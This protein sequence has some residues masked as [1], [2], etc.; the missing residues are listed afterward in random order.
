MWAIF[1]REFKSIFQ[2][3]IGWLF[4]AVTLGLFGLYFYVYNLAYASPYLSNTLSAITFILMITVP[5]LTMRILAEERKNKT[6][7]LILTAPVS[8]GKVVLG[9]YLAVA[10]VFT[11]ATTIMCVTPLILSSFGGIPYGECY[12]AI[13]GYWLFGITCIAIGVFISSITESQVIAAV[14]TF[15]ALFIGYMMSGITGLISS[16]GNWFTKLLGCYDLTT[17]MN[18]FFGGFLD[19]QAVI[20]YLSVS[21]L[22]LFLAVQAIQKRRWSM[23]SKK[24]KTGVFSTG[25]IAVA[26]AAVV[27]VNLIGSQLP[28]S[29][30][31]IDMTSQKLYSIT[32]DTKEVLNNLDED[33]TIYVLV[34]EKSQ[35]TTVQ[36]TLERYAA[37]SRHINIVYKDPAVSPSFYT[38]YT[39]E[40]ISSNSLIVEGSKRSKVINYSNLYESELDYSIYS[41]TTTGYDAEGQLTSAISYVTNEDTPVIYELTG[42]D[43]TALSGS[44]TEAVEKL[45]VEL[46]SLNLL[47]NEAIPE[48]AEGLIINAPVKDFSS[49]DVK[50]VLAYLENGGKAVITAGYTTENM[51]NFES[52][53]EAYGV[54]VVDGM[55][56]E[57]STSAYYQNPFYLLTKASSDDATANISGDYLFIPYAVGLQYTEDADTTEDTDATEDADTTEDTSAIETSYKELFSTTDSAISKVDLENAT[58]Y[59]KEDGDIDGPFT[60]GLH[61]SRS[62]TKDEETKNAE[63]YVFSSANIFTDS[64]SEIVYGNNAALFTGVISQFTDS[65]VSSV[66]PVKNYKYSS[67]TITEASTV[68]SGLAIAIIVPVVLLAAGIVIW[69][70]RR[71]K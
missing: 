30:R 42:H 21:A 32:D 62:F 38:N 50:K 28:E 14:L 10:A 48:D 13:L 49:D 44:F 70:R 57:G 37:Y 52:L 19:V 11:I 47:E 24:I 9:K 2:S 22:C 31:A 4:I 55:I 6:D 65:E 1:K 20:Y 66:I 60:L 43:E 39:S 7:Q 15:G 71:R 40:S 18:E 25:F 3:V 12:T 67:L 33:I 56:A 35:D 27:L 69:A 34:N 41:Y 45:N 29:I 59:S 46:K 64:A 58:A 23:S 51:T 63:V 54:T 36:K 5:I 53:L 8:V 61:V 68:V 16:T 26:V 17:G